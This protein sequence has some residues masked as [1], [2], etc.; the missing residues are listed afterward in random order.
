MSKVKKKNVLS[1][2]I[3]FICLTIIG[4]YCPN[5][6]EFST[7]YKCPAGTYNPVNGS[8]EL[9]DCLDCPGGEYCQGEANSAPTG[10][11]YAGWYCSGGSDSPN[12]TTHG[13]EC[14]PGTYC[15]EGKVFI[16]LN[17][18]LFKKNSSVLAVW[19]S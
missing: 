12:T 2:R 3:S 7:Q 11:C 18:F 8:T 17:L 13:G 1:F 5:G 6:T 16:F 10:Y 15:P 9:A 19:T 14:Q 4:H